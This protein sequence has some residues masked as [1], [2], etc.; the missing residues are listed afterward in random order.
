MSTTPPTGTLHGQGP[1]DN[2]GAPPAGDAGCPELLEEIRDQIADLDAVCAAAV[3]LLDKLPRVAPDEPAARAVSRLGR[4][5]E[6]IAHEVEHLLRRADGAVALVR[7]AP[8]S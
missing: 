3:T 8:A 5:V 4:L 6:H 2:E 7:S 1:Q